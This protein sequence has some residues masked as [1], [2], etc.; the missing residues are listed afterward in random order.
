MHVAEESDSGIVPMNP[1]NKDE[2]IVG[3]EGGGKAADQGE[4]SPT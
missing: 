1:S 3:G 4:H 2:K